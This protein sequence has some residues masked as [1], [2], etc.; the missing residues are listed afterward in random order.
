VLQL[1]ADF[2][3]RD[4][5]ARSQPARPGH[6]HRPRRQAQC[7][8]ASS[9]GTRKHKLGL[10]N[11]SFLEIEGDRIG[12]LVRLRTPAALQITAEVGVFGAVPARRTHRSSRSPHQVAL[13]IASVTF[14][15]PLG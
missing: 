14:I 5:R 6:R 15:V 3:A 10:G 4:S 7:C 1:A 12:R 8:W 2:R 9:T 11:I 13:N